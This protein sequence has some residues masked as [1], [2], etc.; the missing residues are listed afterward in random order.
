MLQKGDSKKGETRPRTHIYADFCRFSLISAR[1]VNLGIW[2]RR[3]FAQKTTGNRRFWRNRFLPFAVS[4]L[5]RSY[6]RGGL[7]LRKRNPL[8]LKRHLF[9][10]GDREKMLTQG[11]LDLFFDVAPIS[12]IYIYI[13]FFFF[14]FQFSSSA[15]KRHLLKRHLTPS[16]FWVGRTP[17]GSYSR[18]GV[19]LPSRCL[20]ENPFL[21]PLLRTL[22][23]TLL[24]SKAHRKTPSKNPS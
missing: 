23:R 5:A 18:K 2:F 1:S 19:F 14:F 13:F 12:D 22:L 10:H 9:P 15:L 6:S 21:E 24:P 16:D 17:R 4:L 20:L 7:R 8:S 11:F 3:R